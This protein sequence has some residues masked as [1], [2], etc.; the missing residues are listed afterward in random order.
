M[1]SRTL[2]QEST[3]KL[4]KEFNR[5]IAYEKAMISYEKACIAWFEKFNSPENAELRSKLLEMLDQFKSSEE[6]VNVK[7]VLFSLIEKAEDSKSNTPTGFQEAATNHEAA[8][9]AWLNE[10][11]TEANPDTDPGEHGHVIDLIKLVKSITH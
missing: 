7:P 3:C 6:D 2:C 4:L 8:Y 10:V 9:R 1:P 11:G 5:L